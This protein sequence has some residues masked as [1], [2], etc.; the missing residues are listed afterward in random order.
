M[1]PAL[2]KVLPDTSPVDADRNDDA[3][4]DKQSCHLALAQVDLHDDSPSCK[5][6][7]ARFDV[8]EEVETQFQEGS[9]EVFRQ[10]RIW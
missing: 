5:S 2:R 1:P 3:K 9:F 6:L 10:L 7:V 8:V 4:Q